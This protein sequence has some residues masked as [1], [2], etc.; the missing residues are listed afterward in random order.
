MH[1]QSFASQPAGFAPHV[2]SHQSWL[3]CGCNPLHVILNSVVSCSGRWVSR[4]NSAS[5]ALWHRQ[6]VV[7]HCSGVHV[8]SH[9][10][11]LICGCNAEHFIL[12]PWCGP[13]GAAL[14]ITGGSV[15]VL[16]ECSMIPGAE[17]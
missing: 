11:L 7:S 12:G 5:P 2:T 8:T 14:G 17:P 10:S 6:M 13:P 15:G 9:H 4:R 3:I 16:S 1:L